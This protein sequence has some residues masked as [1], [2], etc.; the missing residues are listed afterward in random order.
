[1]NAGGDFNEYGL[2]TSWLH[3]R[4]KIDNNIKQEIRDSLPENV[5]CVH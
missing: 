3:D 1:M 5:G 2:K 4:V